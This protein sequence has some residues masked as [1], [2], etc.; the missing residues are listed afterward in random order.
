MK[1]VVITLMVLVMAS[2]V[3]ATV[4]LGD[5]NGNVFFRWPQVDEQAYQK[6][7]L[8]ILQP[9]YSVHEYV[10]VEQTKQ[11]YSFS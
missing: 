9:R 6:E 4:T 7:F 10:S 11:Y 3:S 8:E 2:L 1:L 5:T